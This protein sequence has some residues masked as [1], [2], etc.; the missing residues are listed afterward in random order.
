MNSNGI[1]WANIL[2]PHS[3]FSSADLACDANFS[4]CKSPIAN[5][6]SAIKSGS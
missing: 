4:V 3:R 5:R 2:R 6:N 1:F